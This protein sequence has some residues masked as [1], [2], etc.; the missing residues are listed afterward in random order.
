MLV[1]AAGIVMI[2]T[3]NAGVGDRSMSAETIAAEAP[4]EM[5]KSAGV[6]AKGGGADGAVDGP[7]GYKKAFVCVRAGGTQ[8]ESVGTGHRAE[9]FRVCCLS[10]DIG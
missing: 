10:S 2:V 5:L 3:E 6:A 9:S 7:Y 4:A 1:E 8:A